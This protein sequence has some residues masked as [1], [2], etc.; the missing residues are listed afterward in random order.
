M[1]RLRVRIADRLLNST[2]QSIEAHKLY[3]SRPLREMAA[4]IEFGGYVFPGEIKPPE[5]DAVEITWK[6]KT[7]VDLFIKLCPYNSPKQITANIV[8]DLTTL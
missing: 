1:T 3:F 5:D 4:S 8:L 2:P 7:K 6:T